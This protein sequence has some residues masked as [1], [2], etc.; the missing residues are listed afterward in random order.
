MVSWLEKDATNFA[1]ESEEAPR[2][3]FF[4]DN[5]ARA[6]QTGSTVALTLLHSKEKP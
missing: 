6:T 3:T 5:L 1:R 2:N 4:V